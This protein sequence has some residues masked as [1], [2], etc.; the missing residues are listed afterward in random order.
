MSSRKACNVRLVNCDAVS[1]AYSV[2][3]PFGK[4]SDAIE[5]G[6]ERTVRPQPL[7]RKRSF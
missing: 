5:D 1:H 6:V 7:R 2:T 3:T 4:V